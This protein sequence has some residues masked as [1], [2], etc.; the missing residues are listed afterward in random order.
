MGSSRKKNP[1][2]RVNIGFSP[3]LRGCIR[4]YVFNANLI[5]LCYISS[6]RQIKRKEVYENENLEKIPIA[7]S[8]F[9]AH[10]V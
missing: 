2:L 9:Y 8:Y 5:F 4:T 7:V 3:Y 1:N 6:I 10:G